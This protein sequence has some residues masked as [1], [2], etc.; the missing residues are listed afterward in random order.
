MTDEI[1]TVQHAFDDAELHGDTARLES[2]LA[3]DFRSIGERGYVLNKPQWI[4]RHTDFRYLR[5][6]ISETEV[7]RYGTT[8]IVR[9]AQRCSAVWRD[10]TMAL[11]VRVGHVWIRQDPGWQLAAIQFSTLDGG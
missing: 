5:V 3:D 4:D 6:D 9:C 2:L 10:T 1:L 7:H 8:A 11:S